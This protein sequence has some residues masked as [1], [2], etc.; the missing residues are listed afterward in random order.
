M[1]VDL[2]L[3]DNLMMADFATPAYANRG[4]LKTAE[5]NDRCVRLIGHYDI[6]A[7]GWHVRVDQLSGGNQ[8][9]TVLA[10]EMD[11]RPSVLVAA[12]PTRGLD[13]GAVEFVYRQ[14]NEHKRSG[15]ATLLI[16]TEL[17]EAF[18]LADRIA[19]MFEG[20]LLRILDAEEAT[21]EQVGLLMA[22]EE[23]AP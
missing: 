4:V 14:I 13:V 16:S 9:K 8:Q 20:R 1:A 17:D 12:Q 6:R 15:G 3:R 5:I 2:N 23:T 7:P 21:V 10:R 19:V 18:T 11:R 22:G